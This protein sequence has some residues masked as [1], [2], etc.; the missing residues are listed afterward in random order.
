MSGISYAE[1]SEFYFN[2]P[3]LSATTS[4]AGIP[5]AWVPARPW[6]A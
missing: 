5:G 6:S 4:S 3:I 2:E 1:N